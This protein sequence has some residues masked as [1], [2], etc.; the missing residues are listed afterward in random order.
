MEEK[1]SH[2][3]VLFIGL[4][5]CLLN[6]GGVSSSCDNI[7]EIDFA[8]FTYEPEGLAPHPEG[9]VA[10]IECGVLYQIVP[11]AFE[12]TTCTNG[13]WTGPLPRCRH[14][15]RNCQRHKGLVQ[16]YGRDCQTRCRNR[17]EGG[18]TGDRRCHCD[19]VCGWSCISIS[20]QC[21]RLETP[22]HALPG[23]CSPPY[24]TGKMCTY[25]CMA[26]YTKIGGDNRRICDEHGE[27]IG[28]PIRCER[29]IQCHRLET[30][31][32]ALPGPCSPPYN[33]GK[34][35]TYSCMAGYTKIGGDNRR[36]CDEHGEW[37]GIPIRCERA[38]QC[39]RLETPPHAL[40]G[41]CSP[42][43]NTGKMCTYSCMAGY[44]KIG[45]DNR[46]ICDEHGEW[47]GIPIR[48]ERDSGTRTAS[49]CNPDLAFLDPL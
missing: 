43:Y 13:S 47:I 16:I 5:L 24:N 33:T 42:P 7:N 46:R 14:V 41:P 1:S 40:P 30:P 32:H 9:T 3:I 35:C 11:T 12:R 38:I 10:L 37:I 48:C 18:C 8:E 4:F 2:Y 21:H 44:T 27:W 49:S 36:I 28:I 19:G 25:S 39:H 17:L 20:I 15:P 34:M 29:A 26:G 31:P 22:P 45:G 6:S 23:P